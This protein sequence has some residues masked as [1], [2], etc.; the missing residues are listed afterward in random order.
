MCVS[1]SPSR[2]TQLK[3][4]TTTI[5]LH[6]DSLHMD[7]PSVMRRGLW[8]L[9]CC[10]QLRW[11]WTKRLTT[12][13]THMCCAVCAC[14]LV[15]LCACVLVCVCVCVLVC[16]CVYVC[17][18]VCLCVCACSPALFFIVNALSF[19]PLPHF[20]LRSFPSAAF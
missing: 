20:F 7:R 15:C 12:G 4:S 10:R 17:V 16:V 18:C 5:H 1:F 9:P 8:V 19:L 3:P 11:G 13:N 2:H 14:V 6:P